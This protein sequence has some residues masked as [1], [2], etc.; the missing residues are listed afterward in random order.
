[1]YGRDGT[2]ESEKEGREAIIIILTVV[3]ATGKKKTMQ[4]E[5]ERIC[6]SRTSSCQ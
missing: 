2:D 5:R 3:I 1:M 6:Q 4:R